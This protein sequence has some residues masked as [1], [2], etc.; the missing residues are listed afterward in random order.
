MKTTSIS[1]EEK[2][3][4]SDSR[5]VAVVGYALINDLCHNKVTVVYGNTGTGKSLL[6]HMLAGICRDS[7]KG[8]GEPA[9]RSRFGD[10]V[11]G[12]AFLNEQHAC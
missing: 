9:V 1:I 7:K 10:T 2:M 12:G 3:F 4:H 8:H 11:K 6:V 5:I